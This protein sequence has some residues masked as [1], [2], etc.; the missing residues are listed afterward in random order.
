MPGA[1]MKRLLVL[2]LLSLCNPAIASSLPEVDRF[3]AGRV[4]DHRIP[5]L[6]LVVIRD[7][8]VVHRR[9]FGTLDPAQP[10]VIG[11][12]S[13][14]FTA[15]AVMT[16]VDDGRVELD[17][18]MQ[19]YLPGVR[20]EDPRMR[21]VTVRHLLH[22]TSGLPADAPRAAGREASLAE[23]VR[24]LEA[25][26]LVATPGQQHLYSSPNYQL[27]G[28][29]VEV[30]SGQPFGAYLQAR[31]LDPLGMTASSAT[32]GVRAV[33][34]HALWWGMP[35][36]SPYRWEAGR[37]P[38]ASVVASAD[39]LA[40]FVL[41]NLG[42]GPQV[43]TTA[44]RALLHRGG[45]D[46]GQFSYAMGWREGPTAG[47]R[48]LW[49]GGALPNYRGAVVM[50]PQS[51]SAVIVLTDMSTMFADHTREIAAGVVA[52][53]EGTPQPEAG[54]RLRDV[55][56]VLALASLLLI[57]LGVRG[58]IRAWR[59]PPGARWKTVA[60]DLLLPAAALLAAPRIF[61]VSYRAMWEGAPDITLTVALAIALGVV[62]AAVKL[63]R[64]SGPTVSGTAGDADR[65]PT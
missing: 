5:G 59:H 23:H 60:F 45:A 1:R 38:T 6:A 14:A 58:L 8:Q 29:I 48:S 32:T 34:G 11:S 9:G 54:R 25:V 56:L 15:T 30:A 64:A 31:V 2:V 33:P 26:R 63:A 16:L 21:G 19:R 22:Q 61:D 47:V 10:I 57:G 46:A 40:R 27:L 62:A 44:S 55:G 53:M 50:L 42:E 65:R 36:P 39:D 35:G 24:A 18:P 4:A 41:S 17:A 12:L 52:T 7:G 37:A 13:K 49:H 3:V 51:R 43:L 28:R 20:F